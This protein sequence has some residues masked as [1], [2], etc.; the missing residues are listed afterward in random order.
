MKRL[1]FTLLAALLSTGAAS[2]VSENWKPVSDWWQADGYFHTGFGATT[3]ESFSVGVI[4]NVPDL[5]EFTADSASKRLLGV[6]NSSSSDNAG[7]S[8]ELWTDGDVKGKIAPQMEGEGYTFTGD[9][10]TNYGERGRADVNTLLQKGKNAV[11]ITV[12]MFSEG[13]ALST[14]YTLYI[15]GT[16]VVMGMHF[17][18]NADVY[19]YENLAALRADIYGSKVY[20][21]NGIATEADIQSFKFYPTYIPNDASKETK[22]KFD[23]W[24]S[25]YNNGRDPESAQLEAFL[26]NVAPA[27]AAAEKQNFKI[28]AIA[29]NTNGTVEVTTTTKNSADQPYN[30]TVAIKGKATLEDAEWAKKDD[31]T[32]K[33][34]RAFLEVQ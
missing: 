13:S 20:Y 24:N 21:M 28:T 22:E 27:D 2:A 8:F 34:F 4:F 6:R 26:L 29:V 23:A 7:P 33:F 17:G 32:H 31:K 5:A 19:D 12:E 10:D 11:V 3:T 9:S 14:A 16:M 18:I 1:F 30:G 25:T 15:N